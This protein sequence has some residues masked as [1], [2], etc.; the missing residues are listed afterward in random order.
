MS[1]DGTQSF[2]VDLNGDCTLD[3]L[4]KEILSRNEWG[5]LYIHNV[6]GRF[7]FRYDKLITPISDENLTKSVL[8]VSA[9]GGWSRMD[10][11][12]NLNHE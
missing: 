6:I 1:G 9:S 2:R 8:S 7:E 5:Y 11:S 3:K 4:V 10:Y 12:I